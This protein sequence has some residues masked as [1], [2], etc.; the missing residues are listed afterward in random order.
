MLFKE[1]ISVYSENYK[2]PINTLGG[3]N[4]ALQIVKAGGSIVTTGL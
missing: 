4:A 2:N 3:Q 1:I